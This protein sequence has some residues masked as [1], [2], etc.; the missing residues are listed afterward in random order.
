[1]KLFGRK[2]KEEEVD[3]NSDEGAVGLYF[4]AMGKAE[5]EYAKFA[6]AHLRR[7]HEP[8]GYALEK[9]DNDFMDLGMRRTYLDA[10]EGLEFSVEDTAV[11][12]SGAGRAVG[13]A[14]VITRWTVR[15]RHNRPLLG[16]P[17]SGEEVTVEGVTY[18]TFRNYY[19]KLEYTY[20]HFPERTR[21][22]G[23]Q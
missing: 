2:K 5:Q 8:G 10:L 22:M 19:L 3:R 9:Q 12:A 18:T 20:W 23:E 13:M 17:P 6:G 1:V 21:T 11:V 16:I 7:I 4:T 15:G 14:Q